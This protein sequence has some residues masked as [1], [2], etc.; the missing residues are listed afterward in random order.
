M[1]GISSKAA[2]KQENKY[3]YNGKELQ[4]LEFNDGSGLE[5]FDFTKRFQDPQIG[6]MLQIDQMGEKY[7]SQ[8]PYSFSLNNP[9]LFNDINGMDVDPTN[10]K[11]KD[12]IN[13]FKNILSTKSGIKLIGQ[14][15]HKGQSISITVGSKT[16]TFSFNKEGARAKDNLVL[17]ST[18]A[19]E[20]NP[21]GQGNA[22]KPRDGVS[23]ETEKGS[24]KEIGDDAKYDINKGVSFNVFIEKELSENESTITLG[25]EL[26]T[27]V[28]PNVQRVQLIESKII[29]GTLKP[30]TSEY[31]K[32]LHSIQYSGGIDHQNLGKGLNSLFQNMSAQLDQLK[33]TKQFTE[34]YKKDVNEHK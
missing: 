8:T 22:S 2:S 15:M 32:Q 12:N 1:A 30:G 16:T 26:T 31:L 13:A 21:E 28:E 33:N 10:L 5:L 27:H 18:P 3:K 29:D 19:S 14:F 24:N 6:R 7:Y 23:N 34:L 20:L 25:H 11:G 9:I 4:H 17:S